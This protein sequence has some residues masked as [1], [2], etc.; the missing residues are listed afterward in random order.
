MDKLAGVMILIYFW[1]SAGLLLLALLTDS[2]AAAT[3]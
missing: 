1:S 2:R 3:E